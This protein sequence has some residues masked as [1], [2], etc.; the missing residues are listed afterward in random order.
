MSYLLQL[1]SILELRLE[2]VELGV[3]GVPVA[4]G[5][6]LLEVVEPGGGS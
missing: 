3:D 6:G 4:V 2:A 5:G 1:I